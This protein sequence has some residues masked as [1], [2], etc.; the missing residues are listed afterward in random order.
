MIAVDG[1]QISNPVLLLMV[2]FTPTPGW[3]IYP[4]A[5]GQGTYLKK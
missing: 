2:N 4:F 3:R 5:D 1:V